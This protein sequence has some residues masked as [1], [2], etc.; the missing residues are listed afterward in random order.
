M[1]KKEKELKQTPVHPVLLSDIYPD[2]LIILPISN[3]PLFPG[4][5]MPLSFSGKKFVEVIN[6]AVEK[7]EGFL[8]IHFVKEFDEKDFF[9][10]NPSIEN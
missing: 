9:N 1:A 8:G 10:P 3:R 7:Q 2:H 6:R 5:G 4:F